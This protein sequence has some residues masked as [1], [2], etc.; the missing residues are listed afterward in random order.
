M[1]DSA[2]VST[3]ETTFVTSFFLDTLHLEKW[4]T[5]RR[6]DILIG[7]QEVISKNKGTDL[8]QGTK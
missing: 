5:L 4:S 7:G 2:S 8:L 1:V 6:K 3:R